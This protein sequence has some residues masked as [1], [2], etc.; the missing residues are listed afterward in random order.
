MSVGNN[1]VSMPEMAGLYHRK[2]NRISSDGGW[3]VGE[4]QA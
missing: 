1:R 2:H 3:G 4:A